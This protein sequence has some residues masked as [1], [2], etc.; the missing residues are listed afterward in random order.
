MVKFIMLVGLPGSGKSTYANSLKNKYRIHSSDK[1]REELGDI[2]DQSKNMKVFEILH[3][4]IKDDLENGKN[5]CYDATNLSR[6]RRIAFIRELKHI[7]CKKECVL[8]ATPFEECLKQNSNRDRIVPEEVLYKMYKSF[9]IPCEQEGFDNVFIHY[10]KEEWK[11]YY[12]K[13]NDYLFSLLDYGQENSHHTLT[14][15]QHMIR[16]GSRLLLKNKLVHY[17]V[18]LATILHDVGKPDVKS[19]VDSKGEVDSDAHYYNHHYTGSY[20]CLFFDYSEFKVPYNKE[21]IA[22]L[23][24]HHMKPY[25]EWKQSNKAKEKDRRIFGDQFIEQ[26]ELLHEADIKAK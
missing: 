23:I 22:L 5:V 12:G 20:K 14:L 2:N 24:E 15:G 4:R 8:I 1:I 13:V 21:H 26:V 3:K 19:F 10:P 16:A 9:Q 25:M 18:Y 11:M 6:K 7:P 17:D